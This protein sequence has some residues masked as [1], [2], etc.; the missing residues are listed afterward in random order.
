MKKQILSKINLV[1]DLSLH[2]CISNFVIKS[3]NISWWICNRLS[4]WVLQN[5]IFDF[6]EIGTVNNLC[7]CKLWF[8]MQFFKSDLV[9]YFL[10]FVIRH[11]MKIHAIDDRIKLPIH[12]RLVSFNMSAI[13]ITT[14]AY[15]FLWGY[16]QYFISLLL[17]I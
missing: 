4:A 2:S 8:R 3:H 11:F 16:Y 12:N 9:F 15:L 1:Q 7:I 10:Y 14:V 5:L 6:Y 17:F 13:L